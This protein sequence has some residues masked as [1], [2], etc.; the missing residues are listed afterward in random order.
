MDAETVHGAPQPGFDP[1]PVL[2]DV[3]SIGSDEPEDGCSGRYPSSPGGGRVQTS[4]P[5]EVA[6]VTE[7]GELPAVAATLGERTTTVDSDSLDS[8]R[9]PDLP[10]MTSGEVVPAADP[11]TVI[12]QSN[13]ISP[14]SDPV[15][16]DIQGGAQEMPARSDVGNPSVAPPSSEPDVDT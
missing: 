14:K 7:V 6:R 2:G 15:K 5:D 4:E 16:P 11:I 1:V 10:A 13:P 8:G 12:G 3:S 9:A